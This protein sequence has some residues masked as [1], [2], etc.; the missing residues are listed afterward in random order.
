M[1]S[2]RIFLF[3]TPRFELN[4]DSLTVGRRK[5]VALLALLA[6]TGQPHT[7]DY[8]ATLLWPEH[9]QSG[10]LKNLRR[11]LGRLKKFVGGDFLEVD[12]LQ[13]GLSMPAELV[14][15]TAVFNPFLKFTSDRVPVDKPLQR[16]CQ[17]LPQRFAFK[18]L[19]FIK[20]GTVGQGKPAHE[21]AAVERNGL[22]KGCEAVWA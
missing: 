15:D 2:L 18:K 12:R 8:L 14:V 5:V 4:G 10:A 3:G 6:Y 16:F 13:I 21:V 20:F 7:R 22:G 11:D 19:P 9:D 17:L 1:D